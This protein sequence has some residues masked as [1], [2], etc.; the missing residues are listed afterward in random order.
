M[1]SPRSVSTTST[2]SR[3]SASFKPISSATIDLLLTTSLPSRSR[4]I[5]RMCA[6]ASAAV[7]AKNTLAPCASAASENR[8]RYWGRFAMVWARMARAA[9]RMVSTSTPSRTRSRASARTSMA[10][11]IVLASSG[12]ASW[13]RARSRKVLTSAPPRPSWS[14]NLQ[15]SGLREQ[16]GEMYRTRPSGSGGAAGQVHEASRVAADEHVGAR[17]TSAIELVVGH[18]RSELRQADGERAPKPTTCV[19]S[20]HLDESQ[21]ADPFQEP[22][23]LATDPKASEA[24]TR[25]VVGHGRRERARDPLNLQ[26]VDEELGQL[27]GLRGEVPGDRLLRRAMEEPG[28]MQPNHRGAGP[29]RGYHCLGT[30]ERLEEGACRAAGGPGVPSVERRLP[31][32]RLGGGDVDPKPEVGE[33]RRRGLGDLRVQ[34]VHEAGHEE[35]YA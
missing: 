7:D 17:R 3:A 31:A 28:Q 6:T 14:R 9:A 2:P 27:E 33:E 18:R 30:L 21:S 22:A 19:G 10:C 4:T 11:P 23:A 34:H 20:L 24:M 8:S 29:R 5:R 25:I 35:R 1:C 13:R 16:D 12:V 26:H 32:A 15:A